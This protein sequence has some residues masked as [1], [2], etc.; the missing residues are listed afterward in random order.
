VVLV[1]RAG[2]LPGLGGSHG[3]VL[4]RLLHVGS[5]SSVNWN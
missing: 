2:G 3:L 4:H 1:L 5:Q